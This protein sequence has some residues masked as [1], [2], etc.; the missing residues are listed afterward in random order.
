MASWVL[1]SGNWVC[2]NMGYTWVYPKSIGLASFSPVLSGHCGGIPRPS[3]RSL[4]RYL[5]RWQCAKPTQYLETCLMVEVRRGRENLHAGEFFM[6]NV[7][8]IETTSIK[9]PPLI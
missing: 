2:L 5:M 1:F 7:A 9:H 6:V 3:F 8:Y 4:A